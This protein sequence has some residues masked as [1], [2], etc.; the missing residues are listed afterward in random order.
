LALEGLK[1]TLQEKAAEALAAIQENSAYNTAREQFE[2]Q[3]PL[4][5]RLIIGGGIFAAFLLVM[6][7]PYSYLSSSSDNMNVFEENRGLIQGL[8]RASRT[9]KEAP[10]LPPPMD[11]A[12]LRA[13][14]ERV[15]REKQLVPEQISEITPMPANPSRL[16]PAIVVQNGV[17]AQLRMLNINQIVDLAAAFQNMG[18]GIK[19]TGIDIT[20]TKDQT[21]Y[22]DF[23]ARI[24]SFG[25]P[26]ISLDA[27]DER[28]GKPG[29]QKRPPPGRPAAGEDGE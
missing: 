6:M 25:L 3:T 22:Y 21:H 18:P 26:T 5:Q 4:V 12:M 15:L 14:V 27:G 7:L 13:G 19:L 2:S 10:P 16:A 28:P 9:A 11:Q 1:E 24:V 23:K 8:L 29:A 17:A 20:P